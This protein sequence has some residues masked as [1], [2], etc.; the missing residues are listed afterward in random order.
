MKKLLILFLPLLCLPCYGQTII[1][2]NGAIK[3][4][5]IVTPYDSLTNFRRF[6]HD[7]RQDFYHLIGQTAIYLGDPYTDKQNPS[8]SVGEE[9][10]ITDVLPDENWNSLCYLK[11][12]NKKTGKIIR[13]EPGANFHALNYS[14]VINGYI[15]KLNRLYSNHE[16]TFEGHYSPTHNADYPINC[17]TNTI[18]KKIQEGSIWNFVEIQLLSRLKNDG[19]NLDDRC[20]IVFVLENSEYGKYYVYYENSDGNGE[21][22]PFRTMFELLKPPKE[23]VDLSVINCS[24]GMTEADCRAQLG[25]PINSF[26]TTTIKNGKVETKNGLIFPGNIRVTIEN[27]LVT[28]IERNDD[29]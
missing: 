22:G 27:G 25:K 11:V 20:P 6:R 7:D 12:K 26:S 9:Y 5:T 17:K 2:R 4:E 8:L 23:P 1:N 15:E 3:G 16:Y 28:N 18:N 10:I 21:S 24:I 13:I 29:I 14:W 19:M